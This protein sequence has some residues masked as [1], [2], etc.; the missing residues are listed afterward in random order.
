MLQIPRNIIK[1]RASILRKI[2]S[3][4]KLD[5]LNSLINTRLNGLIEKCEDNASY[6]KTDNYLEFVIKK[7]IKVNTIV[8]NMLVIGVE[9]DKLLCDVMG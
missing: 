4:I 2:A 3:N 7:S 8:K 9:N 6:G 1:E 5:L